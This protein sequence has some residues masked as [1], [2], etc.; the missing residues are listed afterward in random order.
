MI[1]LDNQSEKLLAL[2]Q[3]CHEKGG[4]VATAYFHPS[5]KL[6]LSLPPSLH[7]SAGLSASNE[8]PLSTVIRAGML[9]G[10][11]EQI[12]LATVILHAPLGFKGLSLASLSVFVREGEKTWHS[13]KANAARAR[14]RRS[15]D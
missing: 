9:I 4:G 12:A 15:Q 5:M 3:C 2:G 10:L 7:S 8:A 6:C 14:P 13:L 1:S 11:A